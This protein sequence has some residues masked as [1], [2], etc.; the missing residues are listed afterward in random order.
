MANAFFQVPIAGNEPVL[1]YAPGSLE[2]AE[3]KEKL[4]ELKAKKVTI[5]MYI[6]G[7]KVTSKEKVAIHPP[8]EIG[9]CLGQK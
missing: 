4:A 9:H 1:S 8:H 2:R 6:G 7:K 5:P 3:V